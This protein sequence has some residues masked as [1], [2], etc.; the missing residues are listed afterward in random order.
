MP[1]VYVLYICIHMLLYNVIYIYI[2][3]VTLNYMRNMLILILIEG[4]LEVKL[5]TIWANGKAEVRRVRKEKSR[6]EKIREEQES[7]DRRCRCAK[8]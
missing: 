2:D 3:H 4:S 8:R 7:E 6:R 5:P 1:Y